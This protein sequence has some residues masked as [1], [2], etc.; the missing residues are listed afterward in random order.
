[1]GL[2]AKVMDILSRVTVTITT[3]IHDSDINNPKEVLI[4]K[5]KTRKQV[6][7][8]LI[9]SAASQKPY[10]TVNE[11]FEGK[12]FSF[13]LSQDFIRHNSR[14]K[15][16]LTYQYEPWCSDRLTEYNDN[17]PAFS[18]SPKDLI[19]DTIKSFES[20]EAV[21]GV[22]IRTYDSP[23]FLFSTRFE[24][25]GKMVYAYTFSPDTKR[26]KEVLCIRYSPEISGTALESKLMAA[27]DHA[28]ATYK[29]E[30]ID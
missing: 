10:F 6:F 22:D 15:S 2:H 17:L 21:S 1:M 5:G 14:S 24:K 7:N 8:M 11:E 27:V 18:I 28:A 20:G 26:E 13:E 3:Q 12:R 29:E 25:C 30:N 4:W 19:L 23:Y 16:D 9:E